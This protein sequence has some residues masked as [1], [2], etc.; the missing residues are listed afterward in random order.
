MR[1]GVKSAAEQLMSIHW[2]LMELY[3]A[4]AQQYRD[5]QS[6]SRERDDRR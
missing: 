5:L 4:Q 6:L 1:A 2:N 3:Q